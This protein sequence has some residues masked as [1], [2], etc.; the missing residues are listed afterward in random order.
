[1]QELNVCTVVVG[2]HPFHA[3]RRTRTVQVVRAN[4]KIH[5]LLDVYPLATVQRRMKQI[6]SDICSLCDLGETE[7]RV[8]FLIRCDALKEVLAKYLHHVLDLIPHI[9]NLNTENPDRFL[10]GI[11]LDPSHPDVMEIHTLDPTSIPVL[12]SITRDYIFALHLARTTIVKNI[13]LN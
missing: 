13:D 7:D 11:I 3:A 2:S 5:L 12:E 8:H 6:G 1:M 4:T 10:V 9:D